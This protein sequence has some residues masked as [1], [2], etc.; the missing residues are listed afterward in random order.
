M[1]FTF[2]SE[3]E[4]E[5]QRGDFTLLPEEQYIAEVLG[6]EQDGPKVVRQANPFDKTEEFPNGKPRDVLNIRLRPVS[7]L[8]GDE[9]VDEEG[10]DPGG[11]RKFF[12][13]LDLTKTGLKPQPSKT[14]KFVA[15]CYQQPITQE[16]NV[17][18]WDEL[19]GKRLVV[20]IRHKK[21][22]HDCADFSQLRTRPSRKAAPAPAVT[23]DDDLVAKAKELFGDDA[24]F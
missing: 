13:F 19:V 14:R 11:D 9:L 20:T 4:L 6:G 15:A 3:E 24:S 5:S 8:N 22:K 18:S 10:N 17:G 21:G 12:A 2:K 23:S 1:A 16:L 7:F